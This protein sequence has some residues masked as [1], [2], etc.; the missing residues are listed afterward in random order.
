MQRLIVASNN[1]G[2]IAEIAAILDG[3]FEVVSMY[4]VGLDVDIPEEGGTFE[5]HAKCKAVAC[6]SLTGLPCLAD[7]SGLVVDALGGEPGV[8]TALYAAKHGYKP[9][10]MSKDEANYTLLLSNMEG[11]QDRRAKFVCVMAY[12]DCSGRVS[13]GY[14]ETLGRILDRPIGEG[15][16]GYDPVFYSDELNMSFGVAANT[17]KNAVSHRKRAL[18]DISIR[19]M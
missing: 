6:S 18:D 11:V 19:I 7:D 2:K 3:K 17:A 13:F 15:G 5:A 14:G 16:F 10:G 4:D 1:K 12:C 8:D 9:D